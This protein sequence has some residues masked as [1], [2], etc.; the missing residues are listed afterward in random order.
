MTATDV[1]EA[2][3]Q[4]AIRHPRVKYI[5]TKPTGDLVSLIG[6]ENEVDLI[7]VAQAVHWFDLPTFYSAST[8][9]LKKP[10]GVI[11][12]WGYND[13]QVSPVFDRAFSRF[14]ET[15]LPYWDPRMRYLFDG[16]KTLPFPFEGVGLG[17][18]LI[19]I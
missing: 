16:Y 1:S 6:S 10:G 17:L 15:I 11:A 5:H 2:Q 8:R 9:L 18:S 14:L 12:V 3:I 19:H 4:R 13:V 7:T